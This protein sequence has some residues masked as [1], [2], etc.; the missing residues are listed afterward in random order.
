MVFGQA[1]PGASTV[2]KPFEDAL[3]WPGRHKLRPHRYLG[4][5][6][7]QASFPHPLPHCRAVLSAQLRLS[8]CCWRACE[9]GGCQSL[10]ASPGRGE[11]PGW[12]SLAEVTQKRPTQHPVYALSS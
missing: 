6:L 8:C 2:L 3:R 12:V 9:G 7:V 4:T 5:V 1:L 11:V 10:A